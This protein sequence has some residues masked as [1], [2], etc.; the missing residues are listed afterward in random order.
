MEIF[1]KVVII[2]LILTVLII[3]SNLSNRPI[4]FDYAPNKADSTNTIIADETNKSISQGNTS[5]QPVAQYYS[6]KTNT[7]EQSVSHESSTT[8]FQTN[9]GQV[10]IQIKPDD[11]STNILLE[12]SATES[13]SLSADSIYNEILQVEKAARKYISSGYKISTLN[14]EN[15]YNKNLISEELYKKY[16]ISFRISGDGYEIVI[17][18]K[19][20]INSTLVDDLS[21]KEK[22]YITEN[23]LE[24]VF[25]IKAYK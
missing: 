18:P 8:S 25:W 10:E 21:K 16:D 14:S 24:Y 7:N 4:V 22:V 9:I 15:I 2:F 11:T 5:E 1:V 3:I 6:E 19:F 12:S 23:G 13:I 17:R 20:D